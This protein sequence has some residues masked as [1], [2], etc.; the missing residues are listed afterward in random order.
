MDSNTQIVTKL[1]EAI[2]YLSKEQK[3]NLLKFVESLIQKP[4]KSYS[5]LIDFAGLI[6]LNDVEL[7]KSAIE[8]GCE[9]INFDEW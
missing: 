9:K 8:E 3:E 7:M 4:K 5:S 1:N 2:N 6:P